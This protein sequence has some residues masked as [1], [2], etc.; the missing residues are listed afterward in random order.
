MK[1]GGMLAGLALATI[2]SAADPALV[3]NVIQAQ[4]VA[5]KVVGEVVT[6]QRGKK[7]PLKDGDL[8]PQ[9]SVVTTGENGNVILVFSNGTAIRLAANSEVAVLQFLQ[10]PFSAMVNVAELK[11]EPSVSKTKLRFVR[12]EIVA[13]VKVLHFSQGS[14]MVI[15]TPA[16]MA[17]VRASGAFAMSVKP[18]GV[19]TAEFRLE[20]GAG[21][22]AFS[23]KQGSFTSAHV[24]QPYVVTIPWPQ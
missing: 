1:I 14:D 9:S 16:G 24:N 4:V 23:P 11:E 18:N 8:V 7:A 2:A 22:M 10:D 5:T 3:T 6:A 20:V 19:G 17:G 15:E 12:G 21:G 13:Q